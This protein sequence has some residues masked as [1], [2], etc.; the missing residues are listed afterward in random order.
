MVVDFC[1][2]KN[3][4]YSGW[5][6]W[7]LRTLA[8]FQRNEITPGLFQYFMDGYIKS[9]NRSNRHDTFLHVLWQDISIAV[10]DFLPLKIYKKLGPPL[11]RITFPANSFADN[12]FYKY[13][14]L[15]QIL[16]IMKSV[17]F[18]KIRLRIF[19]FKFDLNAKRHI[20][21]F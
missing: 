10:S 16:Y 4:C 5:W 15:F 1:F 14:Y 12:H 11:S 21:F 20:Y 19:I 3:L 18:I 2:I 17:F 13:I 7:D 9:N 8:Q 6:L